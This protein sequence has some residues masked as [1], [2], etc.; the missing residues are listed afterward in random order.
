MIT[1]LQSKRSESI[2]PKLGKVTFQLLLLGLAEAPCA[3]D[4]TFSVKE[5]GRRREVDALKV[6]KNNTLKSKEQYHYCYLNLNNKS[7]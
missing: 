1:K 4:M 3:L 7:I 6:N 5:N 2:S